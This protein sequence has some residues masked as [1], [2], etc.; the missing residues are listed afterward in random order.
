MRGHFF[1]GGVQVDAEQRKEFMQ[2]TGLQRVHVGEESMT[3]L[4][5]MFAS[6][7]LGWYGQQKMVVQGFRCQV[8]LCF[9]VVHSKLDEKPVQKITTP[10]KA[11][12]T[13]QELFKEPK[14]NLPANKP[15][16]RS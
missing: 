15:R 12:E 1:K 11:P 2:K 13:P 10:E 9:T 5:R 16:K 3:V 6:G 7:A 4:P 8:N 14:A